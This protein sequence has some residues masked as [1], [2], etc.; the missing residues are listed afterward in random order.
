M[1]LLTKITQ[2]YYAKQ[3]HNLYM[4]L[5]IND[6]RSKEA[7]YKNAGRLTTKFIEK[8]MLRHKKKMDRYWNIYQFLRRIEKSQVTAWLY[9]KSVYIHDFIMRWSEKIDNLGLTKNEKTRK[10]TGAE[11]QSIKQYYK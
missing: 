5:A 11:R 10:F 6:F 4:I 7:T 3:R 9:N 1:K 2:F 8:E